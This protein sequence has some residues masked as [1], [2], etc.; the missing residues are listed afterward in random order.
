MK[1]LQLAVTLACF[2]LHAR[3]ADWPQWLGPNRDGSSV[4]IIK[5]WTDAPAVIW[6][7]PV[8]EGHSS[9]V[10]AGGKVVLHH[11]VA[12][13]DEEQLSIFDA[14]T[15]KTIDSFAYSRSPYRGQFGSGPRATPAVAG[16]GQFVS[17]GI[18]GVLSVS[19][20]A[21]K[22]WQA[23]ALRQFN[24]TN[25]R[26]GMS[27]SPLIDGDKAIVH[28]G[29]KGASLVAFNRK[30]G[31]VI[32]K[33]LDDA[34]SYASPIIIDHAGKREIV[35]LTAAGVVGLDA[36]TG[37]T[38]WQFPF[39]D[40]LQESSSTPCKI[41]DLLIVSSV[42]LG[43]VALKLTS[44]DG[45]PAVEQAWKNT[46]LSCYFSTPVPVGTDHVYMVTGNL[47]AVMRGQPQADLCCVETATGKL[48]WKK[49]KVGKYHAALLRTGDNK[50]LLHCDSGDLAL[51][52]PNPTEYRE[53]ARANVCGPT[54]AHPA[55][56]DGKLYVRD[57]KDLIC[58][59][60][61]Q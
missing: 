20:G 5:P 21:T 38:H 19:G 1:L 27:G 18:T 8:G 3:A 24:A 36:D 34:A 14:A 58:I 35:V 42:T 51:I 47:A 10:V 40:T 55:L 61:G 22:Q 7:V 23:D 50:M 46:N 39:K 11:K 30:N 57:E 29:G 31:E 60:L 2:A 44:K 6:R 12:D 43:S 17:F 37:A 53:L 16:D 13:N 48:L 33:A 41:G 9:P 54:W 26:F 15:G 45:K 49:E 4:E 28:V 52:D 32:W 56:S 59:K 25:L